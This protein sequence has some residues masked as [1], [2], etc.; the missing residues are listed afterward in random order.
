MSF[1]LGTTER[2]I[3]SFSWSKC[4]KIR[5]RKNSVFG[6]FSHS[7]GRNGT[8]HDMQNILQYILIATFTINKGRIF[9]NYQCCQIEKVLIP[10]KELEMEMNFMV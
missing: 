10:R 4:R 1:I 5:T 7:G 2:Q 6:H 3:R 9:R 8:T